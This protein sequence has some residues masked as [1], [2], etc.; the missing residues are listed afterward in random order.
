MAKKKMVAKKTKST[1]KKSATKKMA[2]KKTKSAKKKSARKKTSKKTGKATAGGA[3]IAMNIIPLSDRL[4]T[5]VVDAL[6]NWQ[7]QIGHANF[8]LMVLSMLN[9]ATDRS[10]MMQWMVART[11]TYHSFIKD[12][13]DAGETYS[14]VVPWVGAVSFEAMF[15][16][17]TGF[18]M[19]AG[20][21]PAID[22]L[23]PSVEEFV[24]VQVGIFCT[25]VGAST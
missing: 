25:S 13:K 20:E 23:R 7:V 12:A 17:C 3:S 8:R 15:Q 1:K 6:I 11:V 2:A 22:T 10:T 14:W 5:D 19:A 4:R 21:P 18:W 24:N 16:A 9:P